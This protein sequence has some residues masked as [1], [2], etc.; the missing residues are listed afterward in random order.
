MWQKAKTA[1]ALC[2]M[3]MRF[4]KDR[5]N[6]KK[7]SQ[8]DETHK[9]KIVANTDR[10]VAGD[11]RVEDLEKAESEIIKQVQ[12]VAFPSE[13]KTLRNIQ[14]KPNYRTCE[15]DK[16]RKAALRKASS[17][18]TLDLFV[19]EQ[20]ILRVVGRIRKASLS[21]WL[22]NPIILPKSSHTSRW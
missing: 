19:D 22:T 2:M 5:K 16:E 20:K 15:S 13:L 6:S 11:L 12:K 21:E 9:D 7:A 14:G 8:G 4:L 18:H 1:V 10:K 3:Y 17:L